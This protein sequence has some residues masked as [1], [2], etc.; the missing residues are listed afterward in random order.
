MTNQIFICE[1]LGNSW[2]NYFPSYYPWLLRCFVLESSIMIKIDGL[3]QLKIIK[4]TSMKFFACHSKCKVPKVYK[5]I[6][7]ITILGWC[8]RQISRCIMRWEEICCKI[9]G[10]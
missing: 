3:F 2:Y 4:L 9:A 10:R 8:K 7:K 6:N 1:I 5:L